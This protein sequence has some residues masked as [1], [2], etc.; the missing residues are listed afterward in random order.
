MIV[1]VGLLFEMIVQLDCTIMSRM[2]SGPMSKQLGLEQLGSALGVKTGFT[3]DFDSIRVKYS[4]DW[5]SL[6]HIPC[7]EQEVAHSAQ[8]RVPS[9]RTPSMGLSTLKRSTYRGFNYSNS[10][11][12]RGLIYCRGLDHQNR[13]FRGFTLH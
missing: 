13:F 2:L 6:G 1:R 5:D 3:Q 11:S 9:A 12:I 10:S 7:K 8:T 4:R